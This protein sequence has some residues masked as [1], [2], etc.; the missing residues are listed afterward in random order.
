MSLVAQKKTISQGVDAMP[1]S[2]HRSSLRAWLLSWEM[3][4]I[5]LVAAF[6]RLYRIDTTEFDGDQ[7]TIFG[8]AHYALQHGLLVATSNYASIHI[9]NPPGI[10]YLL[11]LPAAI[12]AD[13]LAGSIMTALCMVLAVLLTYIFVRRYY[14]RLAGTIAALLFATSARA[15]FYSR[16]MWQQNLLPLFVILFMFALFRGVVERRRWWLAPALFLLGLLLQLHA[17]GGLLVAP[18]LVAFVLAPETVRWRDLALGVLLLLISY[19]TYILWEVSAHFMDVQILLH[20]TNHPAQIDNWALVYYQLT[21][22]PFVVPF[23]NVHSIL[24]RLVPW[25][26]WLPDTMTMLVIAAGL[27]A[28][29]LAV[30]P[31]KTGREQEKKSTLPVLGGVIN[32]WSNLRASPYRCGLLLL[33]IWQLVPLLLLSRHSLPLY[34]HYFIVFLPGPFILIGV[35]L[36]TLA[37]WF[38]KR[39]GW[40]LAVS[41]LMCLLALFVSVAQF[42]GTTA[43]MVDSVRGNFHDF[44]R[45]NPYYNDLASLKHALT[46]ADQLAQQRH[47][48]RVYVAIDRAMAMSLPYLSEQ[49]HT[50]TTLFDATNCLVLPGP[51]DGPAALLV[52]PYSRFTSALV[53]HFTAS[54][55]VDR[56]ARLGG[57]PFRLYIVN[58][59]A[60]QPAAQTGFTQNLQLLDAHLRAFSFDNAPWLV[61]SWGIMRSA[62]SGFSTTYTY[63]M[64]ARSV[65]SSGLNST[66]TCVLTTLH[67]GDELL[68][69]FQGP[70]WGHAISSV[71]ISARFQA[72]TPYNISYGPF[73]FETGADHLTR[74]EQLETAGGNDAIHLAYG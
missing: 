25:L 65:G 67:P 4:L 9:L 41:A 26:S 18:L 50:P 68:V 31:R 49:M 15:V 46:E 58:P 63:D 42:A 17:T 53:S 59:P 44:A 24:Y 12:S 69:A 1:M 54:T 29:A 74:W 73:S 27:M 60:P 71:A 11:M 5:V 56:P 28:L 52:G 47:L 39:G 2:V 48:S 21:I 45:S 61:T 57:S 19:S 72:T 34:P 38:Q 55:L 51:T 70:A 22:S 36:A 23:T 37:E 62:P 32:W 13:P 7:A 10:V 8:M 16:F 14:G 64:N 40:M 43:D 30:W 20:P 6:L 3:Y 66:S 35:L 33:L